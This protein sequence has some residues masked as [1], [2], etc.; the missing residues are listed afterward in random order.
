MDVIP[1]KNLKYAKNT[2]EIHLAEKELEH[3]T[4]FEHF[5]NL[6]CLYLNNNKV[7]HLKFR[8]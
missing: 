2:T 4:N 1:I 3:V 6:E 8:N 5:P 7:I